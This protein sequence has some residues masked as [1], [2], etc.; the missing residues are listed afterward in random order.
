[1]PRR[2]RRV[3]RPPSPL[4]GFL[5]YVVLILLGAIYFVFLYDYVVRQ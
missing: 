5:P 1:M 2:T 4:D 3:R